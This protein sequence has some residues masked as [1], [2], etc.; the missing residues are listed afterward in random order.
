MLDTYRE[1]ITPEGVALHLP[2]AGPVP[3]A[4]A[5]S[6]DLAIRVA[7][8]SILGMILGLLGQMGRGIY[9]M[10]LCLV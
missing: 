7:I 8:I 2:A 6:I 3:R 4:V 5:W 10:V 9:L 1:V